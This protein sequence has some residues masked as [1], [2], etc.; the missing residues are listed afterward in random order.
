ME[1]LFLLGAKLMEEEIQ[2]GVLGELG[3]LAEIDVHGKDTYTIGEGDTIFYDSVVPHHL[4]ASGND[5]AKILAV[6][7]T[8]Y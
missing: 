3:H 2:L 7:Y 5:K 4:H 8:P 6:L 1:N